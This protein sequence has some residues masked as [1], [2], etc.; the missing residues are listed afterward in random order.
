MPIAF[1]LHLPDDAERFEP[2]ARRVEGAELLLAPGRW[3][4]AARDSRAATRRWTR[5]RGWVLLEEPSP[6]FDL[7]VTTAA[8][9][10]HAL[11]YWLAPG[12]R[13]VLWHE[14]AQRSRFVHAIND[15]SRA[16]W[17][18]DPVVARVCAASFDEVAHLDPAR[19]CMLG[20]PRWDAVIDPAA[21][22]RARC[23]LGLDGTR[24]VTLVWLDAGLLDA[25]W[26]GAIAALRADTD[27]VLRPCTPDWLGRKS[28]WP[29]ALSGPG[30]RISEPDDAIASAELVALADCVIAPPSALAW[31]AVKAGRRTLLVTSA[32]NPATVEL[33]N[34]S[35]PDGVL[36]DRPT[37]AEP[38]DLRAAY[39]ALHAMP[40]PP[41]CASMD[42][43]A[44][45]RWA[46]LLTRLRAGSCEPVLPS[47]P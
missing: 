4:P 38:R 17:I 5:R 19:A 22:S 42:G 7:I 10:L 26:A 12:G 18:V 20:D 1:L 6:R 31:A 28:V 46:E 32:A 25:R 16:T 29:S 8:A 2:V 36:S 44:A 21:A 45:E 37:C 23:A 47:R 9:A 14:R 40:A 43:S 39:A 34:A 33:T 11:S 35:T 13:I 3:T 41:R 30:L 15:G 27:L 24:P